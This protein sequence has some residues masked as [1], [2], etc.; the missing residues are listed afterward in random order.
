[1]DFA[2]IIGKNFFEKTF[3]FSLFL[4]VDGIPHRALK[5][6]RLLPTLLQHTDVC[7]PFGVPVVITT[8][9]LCSFADAFWAKNLRTFLL[10]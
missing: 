5:I 9:A 2:K 10:Y 1:M 6:A 7:P 3:E 8:G 4:K